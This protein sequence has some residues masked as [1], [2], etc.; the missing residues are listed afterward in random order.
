MNTDTLYIIVPCFNEEDVI[1]ETSD[2]LKE[3][4]TELTGNGLI[5]KKS[6]ILFV[7]DGSKDDTWQIISDLHRRNSIYIGLR[8]AY[9]AGH[10]NAVLAGLQKASEFCDITITIDADLQQ[11]VSAID[12]FLEKYFEGNQIVYG[13]R[14]SRKTDAFL[15]KS[16]ALLFYNT[17]NSFGA[18][19]IKNHAD[20]RLMSKPAVLALMQFKEVNLFLRGLIP[21]IGFKSDVVYFDVYNRFAGTSKY[22]FR[23]MVSL[24]LN[25]ITSFSIRPIR[26]IALM[27]ICMFLLS[28][29]TSIYFLVAFLQGLTVSGWASTIVSV[30]AIGG[31]QLFSI[32]VIGEYIGKTY[33]ETKERPRF[34][35][36]EF[37]SESVD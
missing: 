12:K 35:V 23:K 18:K 15:K 13:V 32:G 17:M 16:F 26:L 5:S 19:T 27:G 4:M 36:W 6:R 11:D 10:Q 9:N 24:A 7:D 33:L 20:Y 34:I 37:L 1:I 29:L 28:V 14:N 21:L 2:K 25:G 8:L 31:L 22:T 3:K 30:W